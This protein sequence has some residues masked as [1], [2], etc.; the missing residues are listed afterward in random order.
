MG[1]DHILVDEAQDTSPVQWQV[2]RS[3]AAEFFA[4]DGAREEARTLFAVGDEKQSIYGFQ[5]AAPTMLAEAG[6]AFAAAA[7][8]AGRSWRQIP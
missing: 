8:E 6:S 7:R 4:G 2:I 1:S 5:G 3:L